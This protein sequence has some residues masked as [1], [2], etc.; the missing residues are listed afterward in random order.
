MGVGAREPRKTIFA[1]LM[2]RGY[3]VAVTE[4]RWALRC[5]CGCYGV[6]FGSFSRKIVLRG[7]YGRGVNVS[8][9]S[10]VA[11]LLRSTS[12]IQTFSCFFFF[13]ANFNGWPSSCNIQ[14]ECFRFEINYSSCNNTNINFTWADGNNRSRIWLNFKMNLYFVA[15]IS[16][17]PP[18]HIQCKCHWHFHGRL[19]SERRNKIETDV[20]V[21]CYAW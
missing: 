21:K 3:L 16:A 13:L 5:L 19:D 2:G 1:K 7:C 4:S 9:C 11:D 10:W 8:L 18:S 15:I 6:S 14:N 20:V 17:F 12:W